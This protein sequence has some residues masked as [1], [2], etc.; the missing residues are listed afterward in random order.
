MSS[1]IYR[2]TGFGDIVEFPSLRA[3]QVAIRRC[4]TGFTHT[5]LRV[6]GRRSGDDA[7]VIGRI[8]DETNT[9]VGVVLSNGRRMDWRDA[10]DNSF[11]A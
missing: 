5:V 10:C 1:S 9:M 4:G 7:S 8:L 2:I 3:A 6:S 11:L